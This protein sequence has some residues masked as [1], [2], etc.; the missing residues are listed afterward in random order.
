MGR[1]PLLNTPD[2]TLSRPLPSPCPGGMVTMAEE[3][4]ANRETK[5]SLNLFKPEIETEFRTILP[6]S[7]KDSQLF[8]LHWK[9]TRA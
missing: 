7:P 5:R 2:N 6:K 9:K 1:I 3:I 4:G 8:Y